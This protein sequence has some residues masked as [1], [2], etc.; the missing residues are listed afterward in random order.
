MTRRILVFYTN[1]WKLNKYRFTN[2]AKRKCAVDIITV[3]KEQALRDLNLVVIEIL[4][5]NK[6]AHI[7]SIVNVHYI[8]I[9]NHPNEFPMDIL[10]AEQLPNVFIQYK[11]FSVQIRQI[12]DKKFVAA[13]D[14]Y[15]QLIYNKL[16]GNSNAENNS[17]IENDK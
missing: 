4:R 14:V 9:C 10:L 13:I 15:A 12:N 6:E 11:K 16:H 8:K 2:I 1:E 5:I 3:L 17:N 7:S